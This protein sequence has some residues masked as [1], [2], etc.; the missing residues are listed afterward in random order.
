MCHTACICIKVKHDYIFI[1]AK[2]EN[3]SKYQMQ[4]HVTHLPRPYV[5]SLHI[6][7][8]SGCSALQFAGGSLVSLRVQHV[9]SL[10]QS[11]ALTE[12]TVV[13]ATTNPTAK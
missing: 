3:A 1:V 2:K 9:E 8:C 10:D 11:G 12:V 4:T 5:H 7:L 6:T 13:I